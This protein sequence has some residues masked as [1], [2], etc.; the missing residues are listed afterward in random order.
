MI[1][2]TI[3]VTGAAGK[4]GRAVV[5][6]LREAGW[7]VRALVRKLDARAERLRGEGADVVV[8]DLF[9]PQ[10]L[11]EAMRRASRAYYCPPWHP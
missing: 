10:Q 9:D 2:P 4:T 1:R 3:L 6:R 8:A 11:L 5:S 7:P